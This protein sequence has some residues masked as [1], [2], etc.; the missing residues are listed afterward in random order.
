MTIRIELLSKNSDDA[1]EE[2]HRSVEHSVLCGSIKYRNFLKRVLVQAEP[3]YL[4][5]YEAN[6]LVAGFP[7]F[8]R[9][10]Q[11]YGN[12]LNS[13]PFFGSNGGVVVGGLA[14]NRDNIKKALLEGMHAL[15]EQE[16]VVASTIVSNPLLNDGDF[17][18]SHACHSFRDERIGQISSLPVG[19]TGVEELHH[20]LF[21]M[22]HQKTRNSIRKAQKSGI[23]VTH[24]A[25]LAD[26]EALA[27]LHRQNIEAIGG[28]AKPWSVFQAIRDTFTYDQDY[29]VYLAHKDGQVISAL[30]VFFYNAVAE[31]FTPA[32]LESARIYQPMSL[33]VYEAMQEAVR[34]GCRC[35]NW[36]GTWMTQP[37][38]YQFKSRWG[39]V[40]HPYYY[41][42]REYD[43][44]RRLRRLERRTL[45]DEYPYFYVIPFDALIQ[46]DPAPHI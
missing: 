33:L 20:A 41:Y 10:N 18:E 16:S 32:S 9:R 29:R 8:I 19:Q 17:Y 30:L 44:Y 21:Q 11:R 25:A 14:R 6:R 31:Y 46:L 2:M 42:V 26:L 36:G 28:L 39:T 3:Q 35:W 45:L 38:V 43:E 4:V 22:F 24:S 1:Y 12:V 5:A 34:R 37:G 13:L 27:A 15:A 40:D 23:V 7:L